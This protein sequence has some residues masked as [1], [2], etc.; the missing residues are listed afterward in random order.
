MFSTFVGILAINKVLLISI[1]QQTQQNLRINVDMILIDFQ[2]KSVK[3]KS[4]PIDG[5]M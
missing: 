2:T 3:F 5:A 4:G 1:D